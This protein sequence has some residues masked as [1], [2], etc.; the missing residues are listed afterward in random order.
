VWCR[1]FPTTHWMENFLRVAIIWETVVPSDD[2]ERKNGGKMS[3]PWRHAVHYRGGGVRLYRECPPTTRCTLLYQQ[4][5]SCISPCSRG[6][7]ISASYSSF[8]AARF[9]FI[10]HASRARDRFQLVQF[11]VTHLPCT[12]PCCFNEWM[13]HGCMVGECVSRPERRRNL[14]HGAHSRSR[15]EHCCRHIMIIAQGESPVGTRT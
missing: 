5:Y 12:A 10:S 7:C 1:P 6:I 11:A 15:L 13:E 4:L 8:L 3:V 14:V 2:A 9:C